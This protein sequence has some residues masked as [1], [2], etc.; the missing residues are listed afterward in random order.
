[1]NRNEFIHE[2]KRE[3]TRLP[4]E[5]ID[6]AV[7][8]YEEYFD[9]AG[10]ENEQ[11]V[12]EHLGGPKQA[13]SQIKA[14][15]AVRL[16]DEDE[17][18]VMRKGL[19]AAWCVVLAICSAPVSMPLAAALAALVIAIFVALAGCVIGIFA[20]LLGCALASLACLVIGVMAIPLSGAAAALLAG[21]GL[22]AIGF[23]AAIGMLLIMGVKSGIRCM[24]EWARKKNA[25]RHARDILN[26]GRRKK[27]H[28]SRETNF[29][30]T[31]SEAR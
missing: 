13:A 6:A 31:E 5:E 14:E 26:A 23:T 2:L 10:S 18:P 16:F 12:I 3:L 24:V 8:Y 20:G 25:R 7:E 11:D 9:E 15:Y 4:E 1:M 28:S 22:A 21:I 17:K 19:S 27:R 30:S 29:E